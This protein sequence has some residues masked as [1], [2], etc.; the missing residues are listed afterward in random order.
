MNH[1]PRTTG[2]AAA[3]VLSVSAGLAAVAL[4]PPVAA[5]PSSADASRDLAAVRAATARYHD[6]AAAQADGYQ[7]A[8]SCAESPEGTMG[9][10]WVKPAHFAEPLEVTRPQVLVYQPS[11]SGGLRLVAVEYLAWDGDQDLATDDDRPTLFGRGFDGPMP[12]HEEGMP[13]HYDLHV[14]VWQHNPSGMFA[15]W[16]PA[17]SCGTTS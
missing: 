15:P 9:Y 4:S 3:A 16:N 6:P 12:G 7:P 17:G 8:E 2:A 11:A 10:H 14:W 13:I 1:T 5:S